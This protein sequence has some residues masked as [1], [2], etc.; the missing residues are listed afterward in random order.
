M[1]G[2]REHGLSITFLLPMAFRS[3][4]RTRRLGTLGILGIDAN[5]YR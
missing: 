2:L 4:Q 5:P 3:Y 1:L